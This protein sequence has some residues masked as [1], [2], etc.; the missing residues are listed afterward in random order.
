MLNAK[1]FLAYEWTS[2]WWE[3]KAEKKSPCAVALI[4]ITKLPSRAIV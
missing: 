4:S 2:R 1:F 3:A